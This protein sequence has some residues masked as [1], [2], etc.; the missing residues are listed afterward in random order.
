[1]TTPKKSA[2][3]MYQCERC[4]YCG[5]RL[6]NPDLLQFEHQLPRS[7]GGGNDKDNVVLACG[8]C[9]RKKGTRTPDEFLDS[10]TSELDSRLCG[11]TSML[12][13]FAEYDPIAVAAI[14]LI[15]SAR[16]L[17]IESFS[18]RFPGE[19]IPTIST[20]PID[21]VMRGF[22]ETILEPERSREM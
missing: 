1:M 10:L 18:P 11:A 15:E 3:Q 9:N 16:T 8:P 22:G 2:L 12:S 20:E 13:S 14:A 5:Y 7:R 17:L 4:W 6:G 19:V 21:L